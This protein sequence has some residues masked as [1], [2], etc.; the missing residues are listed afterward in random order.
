MTVVVI[1]LAVLYA[2][3]VFLF[4]IYAACMNMGWNGNYD[5]LGSLGFAIKW[6]WTI[7]RLLLERRP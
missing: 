4:F 6:P 3:G 1:I 2:I 7:G 5:V